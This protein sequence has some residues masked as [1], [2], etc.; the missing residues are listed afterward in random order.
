MR[1]SV[2][3]EKR[4]ADIVEF[5][6]KRPGEIVTGQDISDAIG[7]TYQALHSWMARHKNLIPDIVSK[8]GNGIRGYVLV[9]DGQ[10]EQ[11]KEPVKTNLEKGKNHEGY[12][13]P[14]MAKA[15]RS[16]DG[17]CE[18]GEVWILC[19]EGYDPEVALIVA[20]SANCVTILKLYEQHKPGWQMPIKVMVGD[21][22]YSTDVSELSRRHAIYLKELKDKIPEDGMAW[23]RKAI[24]KYL[25]T[26]MVVE[27]VV[28]KEVPKI[29]VIKQTVEKTVPDPAMKSRIEMLEAQL[30]GRERETEEVKRLREELDAA[31][32]EILELEDKLK[33]A[34]M[35][36]DLLV[37]QAKLAVYED[38]FDR[39]HPRKE[40]PDED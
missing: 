11:K 5:M 14:T 6:K 7:I 16:V 20:S 37:A 13:D 4:A 22:R 2:D 28:E 26:T 23:V 36:P 1:K 40:I 9:Q 29:Q 34:T 17:C 19:K 8:S 32:A 38:I 21:E 3:H 33:K 12:S 18:P 35:T 15:L 30:A 31:D 25:R 39:L 24:G 27:K 10:P